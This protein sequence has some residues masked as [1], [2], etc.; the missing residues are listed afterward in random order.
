M[1]IKNSVVVVTG[2]ASGIGE[3]C[4]RHL[5]DLGAKGVAIFDMNAERGEALAS[6]LGPQALFVR[7]DVTDLANVEAG[8]AATEK[9]FGPVNVTIAAAG[10]TL[11]AKLIGRNG[12][13][14]M[15]RFDAAVKINLY[16]TLHVIR[17][18]VFSMLKAEPNDDGERGVIINVASGAAFE[19]QIGQVGYSA[20]KAG[21]V[22]M[23]LP[24]MRELAPHG[25]RVVTIAPGAFDTPIYGSMAPAVRAGLEAQFLFPKRMGK[26]EEFAMFVEEILRNPVHN[27]RTY[28]F[29][30]GNILNP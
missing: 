16:G 26:P 9:R 28:R 18:A 3:A 23:T 7:V 19:G 29:D 21:V 1:K 5:I 12:P 8:I 11:P 25:I 17:S 2:G 10:V 24:L 22:G 6:T 13:I 14:P 4:C 15:E 30:S 20:A 27:G